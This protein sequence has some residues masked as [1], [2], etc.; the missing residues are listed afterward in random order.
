[1][2]PG[3]TPLHWPASSAS[4]LI[5]HQ[6][7]NI[8]PAQPQT[9]AATTSYPLS[10][11]ADSTETTRCPRPR[12]HH[13]AGS[14]LSLGNLE[15]QPTTTLIFIILF[16]L[17]TLSF[18]VLFLVPLV[19]MLGWLFEGFLVS[20]HS[21]TLLYT[22]FLKLLLLSSRNFGTLCFYFCLFQNISWFPLWFFLSTN[23]PPVVQ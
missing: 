22:S 8:R 12:G 19:V 13:G 14:G 10:R 23:P 7:P 17:L 1:M 2:H 6:E 18:F 3:G 9:R 21:L 15:L 5:H 20:W 4:R 16:L 11:W